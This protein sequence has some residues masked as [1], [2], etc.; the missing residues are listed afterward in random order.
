ML[1]RFT[2]F[3]LVATCTGSASA[4]SNWACRSAI[5][6]YNLAVDTISSR[7]RRYTTC[8]ANSQGRDECSIEFNSLR[9]AHTDFELSISSYRSG[10]R[11]Y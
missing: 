10:C 11:Q 6:S 5:D 9:S 1:A 8:V 3:A 2:A 4:Q 7:I